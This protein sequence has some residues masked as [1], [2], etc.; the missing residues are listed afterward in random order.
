MLCTGQALSSSTCSISQLACLHSWSGWYINFS[1][2]WKYLDI[3][4]GEV[5][6]TPYLNQAFCVLA[7]CSMLPPSEED[8]GF[9]LKVSELK[10]AVRAETTEGFSADFCRAGTF[11]DIYQLCVSQLTRWKCWW[12]GK[13]IVWICLKNCSQANREVQT[14][15][16]VLELLANHLALDQ[17]LAETQGGLPGGLPQLHLIIATYWLFSRYDGTILF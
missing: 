8:K 16:A 4:R 5:D 11:F 14:D 1:Q 10:Y 3:I 15:V 12:V 9:S 7:T 13:Y 2:D 17:A 6:I